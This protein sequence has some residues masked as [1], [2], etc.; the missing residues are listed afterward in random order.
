MAN[1][2]VDALVLIFQNSLDSVKVP[3]DWKV[4]NVISLFRKEGKLLESEMHS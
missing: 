4:V 2:V 3:S 1:E